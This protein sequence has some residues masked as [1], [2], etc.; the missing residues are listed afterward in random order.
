MVSARRMFLNVALALVI[1]ALPGHISEEAKAGQANH[2]FS[3]D[4]LTLGMSLADYKKSYPAAEVTIH[5]A[6]RYCFGRRVVLGELN[7]VS[8][9]GRRD[10]VSIQVIFHQLDQQF[11]LT[12]LK[13]VEAID[14]HE[15]VWRG[16][17]DRMVSCGSIA[18]ARPHF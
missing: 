16:L 15:T 3:V 9:T 4:G 5:E 12:E 6:S 7:W 14:P 11:R 1:G 17:R 8:A 10:G 2:Y 18:S 13:R